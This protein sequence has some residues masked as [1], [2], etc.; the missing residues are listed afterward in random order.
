M[1]ANKKFN[2][3]I[4]TQTSSSLVSL[5]EESLQLKKKMWGGAATELKHLVCLFQH[6]LD[7]VSLVTV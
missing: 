5:G 7:G 3:N 1:M 4:E 6:Q 2:W